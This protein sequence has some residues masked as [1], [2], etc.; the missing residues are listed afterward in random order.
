MIR[1]SLYILVAWVLIALIGGVATAFG[2]TVM[3]PAASAV[4]IAHLGF[5]QRRTLA[6]DLAT[7]IAIGY[8]EDLHQ[9]GPVGLFAVAYALTLL[10]L[11]WASERL[12]LGSWWTRA[13]MGA[14][15][16][17]LV[18]LT[19]W[20]TLVLLAERLGM[21]RDALVVAL[22]DLHWHALA[23]LLVS[24]VVWSLLDRVLERFRVAEGPGEPPIWG[25]P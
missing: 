8:L 7:A 12:H 11:K 23:T 22:G 4:V 2:I 14:I 20:S 3:L 5:S 17:V 10:L 18:D 25:P 19:A 21:R 24:P 6:G 1:A 9:G 16:I 13:A 15:S